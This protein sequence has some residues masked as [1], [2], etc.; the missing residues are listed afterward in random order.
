LRSSQL[1]EK[2]PQIEPED[3]AALCDP[4]T[5]GHREQAGEQ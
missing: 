4:D 2:Y 5:A 1:S 3:Q